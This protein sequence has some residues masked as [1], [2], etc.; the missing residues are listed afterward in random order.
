MGMD[1]DCRSLHGRRLG[2]DL[3]HHAREPTRLH[4]Q[5]PKLR[6]IDQYW[7]LQVTR[8]HR[9]LVICARSRIPEDCSIFFISWYGTITEITLAYTQ[10]LISRSMNTC[11]SRLL[12][13]PFYGMVPDEQQV[14]TYI[15]WIAVYCNAHCRIPGSATYVPHNSSYI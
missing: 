1:R 15:G 6:W 8:S 9:G 5:P 2:R 3:H 10:V 14:L 11:N 12:T 4:A 7:C 13:M